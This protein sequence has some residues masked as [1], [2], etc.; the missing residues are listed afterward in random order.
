MLGVT[1]NPHG[2]AYGV[3]SP[4]DF[5]P[6]AAKTGTAQITLECGTYN[7]LIAMAPAGPG[8]TP[9]V[10][11]AAIVPTPPGNGCSNDATGALIAGPVV[12]AVLQKA[13]AMQS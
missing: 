11:V 3:F 10:A 12:A 8:E 6:V 5:P 4:S 2:T 1:Q 7:W 9:T 13:L